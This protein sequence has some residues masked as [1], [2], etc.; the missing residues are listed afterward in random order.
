MKSKVLSVHWE[1]MFGR[2]LH[3]T[4][5]MVQQHRLLNEIASLIDSGTITTT[6]AQR[7]SPICA[8]TLKLAHRR[9]E[10]GKVGGK[11]VVEGW[12]GF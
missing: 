5:D 6:L 12:R 11:V 10:E 4:A 9:V 3:A 2:S 8:S 1:Y 7:L